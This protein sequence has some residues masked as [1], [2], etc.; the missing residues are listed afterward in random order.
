MVTVLLDWEKAFDKI[1]QRR[2]L[3]A[4]KRVGIPLNMVRVIEAMYRNPEFFVK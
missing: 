4:L 3:D 1:H 2:L